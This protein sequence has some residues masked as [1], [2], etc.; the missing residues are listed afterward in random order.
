MQGKYA[1]IGITWRSL[2]IGAVLIPLNNYWIIQVEAVWNTGHSTCLSLM[3]HVVINLLILVSLNL[4]LLKKFLPKYALT[5][6]EL[7]D[8]M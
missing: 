7:I 4:F 1:S 2:I 8:V 5:E 3:W 6:A